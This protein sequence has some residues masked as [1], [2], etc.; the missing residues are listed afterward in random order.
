MIKRVTDLLL[1]AI[2]LGLALPVICFCAMLIRLDSKGPAFFCQVRVGRYER[3]FVCFK[4]RTMA[5]DTENRPTHE[6]S[7]AKITPVGRVLRRHKL[8]ELPQLLNVVFG[9]MSLVGPRPC[10]P[11]Q[12]ELIELRKS[13]GLDKLRPGITGV[14]QVAGIDMSDPQKLSAYDAKYLATQSF[15]YDLSLMVSTLTRFSD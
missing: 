9:E 7:D 6:V 2:L 11:Q 10:L 8:D 12:T 4:L 5:G 14:S 1:A 13:L 15:F 3:H